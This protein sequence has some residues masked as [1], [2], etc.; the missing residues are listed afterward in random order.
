MPRALTPVPKVR[1]VGKAEA[2]RRLGVSHDTFQRRLQ[3]LFT[4]PRPE[5]QRGRGTARV[6]YED[7]LDAAVEAGGL[8]NL[9]RV[10]AAVWAVR[11]LFE[12]RDG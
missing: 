5:G 3:T 7:E 1:L 10:I 6:V 9:P 2:C 12:R 11:R 4:D 8:A